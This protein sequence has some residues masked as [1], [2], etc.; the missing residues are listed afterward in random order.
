MTETDIR[1]GAI[2]G[3]LGAAVPRGTTF[4]GGDPDTVSGRIEIEAP[5]RRCRIR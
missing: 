1:N 4:H 3:Q 2:G 5:A